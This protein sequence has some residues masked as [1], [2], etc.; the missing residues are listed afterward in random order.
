M[1]R[2]SDTCDVETSPHRAKDLQ[3]KA[4]AVTANNS[5]PQR[6]PR[7][8]LLLLPK[9]TQTIYRLVGPI[10]VYICIYVYVYICMCAYMYVY[11][12]ICLYI[13]V[14][15][16]IYAHMYMYAGVLCIGYMIR[17]TILYIYVYILP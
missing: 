4:Q 7:I 14:Y 2:T 3:G 9:I 1:L 17:Y 12:C 11:I 5:C 6:T 10:Y 13:Y 8:T 15:V 16:C